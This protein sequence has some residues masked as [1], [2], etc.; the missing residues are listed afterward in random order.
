MERV[1][2]ESEYTIRNCVLGFKCDV[3]WELM[4]NLEKFSEQGSEIKFC[5]RCQREVYE[6]NSDEELLENIRLNRCV[7]FFQD[8]PNEPYSGRLTGEVIP[9]EI[10]D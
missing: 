7:S 6:S 1:S 2:I 10:K 3:N 8:D 9:R 4:G 5:V